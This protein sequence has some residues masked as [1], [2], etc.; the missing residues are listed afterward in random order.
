[1]KN[2]R[3]I[4]LSHCVSCGGRLRNAVFCSVCGHSSCSWTCHMRHLAQH[5]ARPG[6]PALHPGEPWR[7]DRPDPGGGQAVAG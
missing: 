4:D 6:R 1:M 2:S 7:E 3:T 5:A